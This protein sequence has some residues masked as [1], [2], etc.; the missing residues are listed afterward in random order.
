MVLRV[1]LAVLIMV[2]AEAAAAATPQSWGRAA[3]LRHA[4]AAHAVASDGRTIYA[5]AGTDATGTPVREVE[6]FDGKRWYRETQLPGPGLNAPAA[7]LIDGR[8]YVV[9]GFAGVGN[10]PIAT[11]RVYD[12]ATKRWSIVA[13][14]PLPRGGHAAVV[15][16][17]R[18]HVLG[19]GN[20]QR[21]LAD[22]TV[23]DPATDKWQ[24]LEPLPR[25]KG[26][27]AAVVHAGRIYAIGGRS[28][29]SDFGDVDVYDPA[30]NRWTSGPKIPPRGTAGAASYRGRIYLFGGESQASGRTLRSVLRLDPGGT[31][32]KVGPTMPAAKGFARVVLFHDAVYVVG[33]SSSASSHAAVGSKS[34]QRFFLP[35]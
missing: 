28:G 2:G 16:R 33:G 26:S 5:L 14:L 13:A 27:V 3:A 1:V 11:T 22:H 9:G 31:A 21:T 17:G 10:V 23:Y 25:S 8:I 19:G 34:V 12:L 30:T 7:A 24:E 29:G 20:E 6:R 18:I 35:R 32:W 15:L 4:R